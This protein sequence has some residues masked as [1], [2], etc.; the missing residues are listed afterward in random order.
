MKCYSLRRHDFGK[1]MQNS[2]DI[3]FNEFFKKLIFK[4]KAENPFPTY[5]NGDRKRDKKIDKKQ[6]E[7]LSKILKDD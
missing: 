2:E 5:T 1:L 6:T 7:I 3:F 4:E